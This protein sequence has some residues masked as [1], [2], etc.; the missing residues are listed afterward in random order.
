MSRVV[1]CGDVVRGPAGAEMRGR[2]VKI[3]GKRETEEL[4]DK[5]WKTL[6]AHFGSRGVDAEIALRALSIARLTVLNDFSLAVHFER[7]QT[8]QSNCVHSVG[9]YDLKN[10]RH[11]VVAILCGAVG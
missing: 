9:P 5:I 3:R 10:D 4:A 11:H 8:R 1:H 2:N 6:D 7:V